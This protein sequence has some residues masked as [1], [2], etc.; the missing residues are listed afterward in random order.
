MTFTQLRAFVE[1]AAAGSVRQAAAHLV[2][3]QPAVSAAVAALQRELGVALVVRDGRGL[4]V[5]PAGRVFARYA[6]EVLGLLDEARAAATGQID[7]GSGRLRLAAVTTAGE[8]VL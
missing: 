1:V 3:S 7:P 4:Q 6:R 2:V 5:T 8:H